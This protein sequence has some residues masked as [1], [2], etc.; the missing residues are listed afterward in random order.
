M[1]VDG[2]G[3]LWLRYRNGCLARKDIQSGLYVSRRSVF[4]PYSDGRDARKRWLLMSLATLSAAQRSQLIYK[5][6]FKLST[7]SLSGY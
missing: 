3:D 7:A 1:W 5:L 2:Q 6:K 4:I